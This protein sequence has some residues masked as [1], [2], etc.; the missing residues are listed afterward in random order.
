MLS[1]P[2]VI[3][4]AGPIIDILLDYVGHVKLCSRLIEHLDSFS[5][6]ASIKEK[7]SMKNFINPVESCGTNSVVLHSDLSS[8][9]SLSGS[10]WCW[11]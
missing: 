8:L 4:W 7:A 1:R 6:W 2:R 5:E 11:I 10:G 9:D 3:N